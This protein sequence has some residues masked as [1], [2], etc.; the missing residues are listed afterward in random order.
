MSPTVEMNFDGIVGPTH[1]YAGLA[2]DNVASTE[3][4][5]RTSN[6]RA[7]ALEGI[8]KMRTLVDLG[9]PQA[10][11]P[12]H[13]RPHMPTLRRLGFRG[14]DAQVLRA[15][16][17]SSPRLLAI[18]SSASAMWAANAATVSPSSDTA[19]GRVHLTPANLVANAHRSIEPDTTHRVLTKIF[20]D[21]RHFVVHAPLPSTMAFADEGAA[22]HLRLG[23]LGSPGVNLMVYGR[24]NT[25]F[26]DSSVRSRQARAASKAIIR[27]HGIEG[28]ALLARQHPAAISAGAFHND[29]VAVGR[30]DLLLLHERTFLNQPGVLTALRDALEQRCDTGLRALV[31][32]DSEV[33]L[34]DAVRAYLFNGQLVGDAAS[35]MTLVI[36][37]ECREIDSVAAWIA[38]AEADDTNPIERV[39]VVDVRQSMQNGGG[40]ACL[41]LLVPLTDEERP[42]ASV[43]ATN[44]LL[45][46]LEAWVVR[47]HRDRL[48]PDDLADPCL[49]DES[50]TALDELSSLLELGSVYDFQREGP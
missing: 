39:V 48:T 22:N 33:P 27:L 18:C 47:H 30:G 8:A 11:L 2:I 31:V 40:P 19:D 16:A 44:Q 41:R 32:R 36:P 12:P 4:R 28:N 5:S 21:E 13:D 38:R 49:M 23:P 34:S 50:R 6:P 1:N 37:A 25:S 7:A 9:V 29:V 20:G 46:Q 26:D 45:D 42:L 24:S 15:A 17:H 35:R 10:V 43:V 14:T 3:S